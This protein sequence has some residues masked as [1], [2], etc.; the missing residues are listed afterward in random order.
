MQDIWG[1]RTETGHT[2]EEF[3]DEVQMHLIRHLGEPHVAFSDQDGWAGKSKEPGPPVD[4]MVIPPEGERRFA[5]VCTYGAS[6]KKGGD[7]MAPGGKRRME[8][9]LATPQK[10]DPKA[11]LAMLNLA[12]NTVRQFAKL[13]HIQ[14]VRVSPGET[15]QF[16]KSPKPVFENTKQV[17]FAFIRPRLPADGFDRL[18]LG[19]G[20]GVDFWAPTPIYRDELEAAMAHG[21][22]KLAHALEEA[23]VTEMLH[24]DRPSAARKAY[25]LR[26]SVLSKIRSLFRRA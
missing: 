24:L 13:V 14:N 10:G 23:G 11:D 21:T 2:G 4:V 17:A 6:L 3:R 25:G 19:E 5:Y 22:I 16:S 7:T 1:R 18:R 26:R 15:V 20:E 8:F 9:V 12:A